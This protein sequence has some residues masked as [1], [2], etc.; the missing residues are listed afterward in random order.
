LS[1]QAVASFCELLWY[2]GYDAR[3]LVRGALQRHLSD[4]WLNYRAG[5]E[6]ALR[7]EDPKEGAG[8]LPAALAL[9][10]T[11]AGV[12]VNLAASLQ[13]QGR[14]EEAEAGF[15]KAIALD[16]RLL[17]AYGNLTRLLVAQKRAA[18]AEALLRRLVAAAP[19]NPRAHRMLGV[20]L[21]EQRKPAEALAHLE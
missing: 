7:R 15:R 11:A 1:P 12:H 3:P 6:L 8:Y 4:F 16:P 21:H 18:E 20:F 10:P 19:D 5:T 17:P 2:N 14:R 9:R 13:L